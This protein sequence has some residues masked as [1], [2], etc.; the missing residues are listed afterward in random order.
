[1]QI[2]RRVRPGAALLPAGSDLRGALEV[3][4]P[5]AVLFE[6]VLGWIAS[7]VLEQGIGQ[8]AHYR[9]G[10]PPADGLHRSPGVGDINGLV[11]DVA[12]VAG[13]VTPEELDDL[14][15]A[16][17]AH[18]CGDGAV[19]PFLVPVVHRFDEALP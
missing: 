13:P 7:L 2:S 11:A 4:A 14:A 17:I 8:R 16:G 19:S 10:M 1:E 15:G 3:L 18:E 6:V 12:E 5:G 9:L